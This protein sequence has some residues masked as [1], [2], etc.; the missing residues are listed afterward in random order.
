[1]VQMLPMY[2]WLGWFSI[3]PKGTLMLVS[4]WMTGQGESSAEDG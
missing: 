4:L 3:K 1:M 2:R